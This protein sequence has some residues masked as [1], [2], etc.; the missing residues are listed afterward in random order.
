[1]ESCFGYY[2]KT[3]RISWAKIAMEEILNGLDETTF[4]GERYCLVPKE[5]PQLIGHGDLALVFELCLGMVG[6]LAFYKNAGEYPNS[7]LLT[8][9]Y[10]GEAP[11]RI[12]ETVQAL[13][14]M[15]FR[16]VPFHVEV[17]RFPDP[18]TRKPPC[19]YHLCP[20]LREGENYDVFSIENFPF[21][22][23]QNEQDLR[24]QI[25]Y[26]L[27]RIKSCMGTGKFSLKVDH[28]GTNDQPDEALR[29]MFIGRV[30]KDTKLG[31]LILADLDHCV[32]SRRRV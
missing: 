4:N 25:N 28:H 23:V 24:E 13:G 17:E 22:S 20:D 6:K 18:S 31:E 11:H 26:S 19:F 14:E 15:G 8:G 2:T 1:M 30:K 32:I 5:H 27:E 10:V 21:V 9:L 12:E 29:K 16:N 3:E 7:H